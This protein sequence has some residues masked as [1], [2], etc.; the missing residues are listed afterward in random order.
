MKEFMAHDF[1]VEKI[2]LACLVEA[3][4]G[5]NIHTN[6]ASHGIAVFLDG[7]MTIHFDCKKV[8]VTKNTIVY[9]PK[10]S[11]YII[12]KKKDADC[13]CIN[14]QLADD[15]VFEPFAFKIK[16][17]NNYM[18]SFKQSKKAWSKKDPGHPAK[19]KA[20]LYQIIYN[21]Q[22][23]YRIPYGNASVIQPAL[24][25]IHSN[26][27]K[28][29]ISVSYLAELCQIS[30]VHLRNTFVK[31]FAVPPIQYINHLRLSRAKELLDSQMYA[32]SETCFLSGYKDESYFSRAFKRHFG[33]PPSEYIKKTAAK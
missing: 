16:N 31:R 33:M 5:N 18:E 10:G 1:A 14:F 25:Y 6:R 29:T 4:K 30:T 28:E 22:T 26:Y 17:I 20:E 15:T 9:F 12:K 3:G 23:E 32:V 8:K 7:D 24:D 21:M 13:Y 19:V 11:N 27:D 2:V